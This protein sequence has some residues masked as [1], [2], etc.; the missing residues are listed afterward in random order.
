VKPAR[1][2]IDPLS[3]AREGYAFF[4][5]VKGKR[6]GLLIPTEKWVS[7]ECL[8]ILGIFLEKRTYLHFTSLKNIPLEIL[9]LHE[10]HFNILCVRLE[11][12][13]TAVI[14]SCD[15]TAGRVAS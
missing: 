6:N 4:Y 13:I 14:G 15:G 11:S 5:G 7:Q 9:L 2:L 1:H 8:C 3:H 12:L 10:F